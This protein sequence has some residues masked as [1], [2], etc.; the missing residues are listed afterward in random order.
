MRETA[1]RSSNGIHGSNDFVNK[2]VHLY[3]WPRNIPHRYT[4]TETKTETG[5]GNTEVGFV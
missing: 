5:S 4:T 2:H 1:Q 3:N